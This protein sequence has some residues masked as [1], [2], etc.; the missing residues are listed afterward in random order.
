MLLAKK[1]TNPRKTA[2]TF[3]RRVPGYKEDGVRIATRKEDFLLRDGLIKPSTGDPR[4]V[5][6]QAGAIGQFKPVK[7]DDLGA[8][9]STLSLKGLD[10]RS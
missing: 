8:N 5:W 6:Q 10:S 7:D 2:F 9:R 3:A 4:Q 1:F